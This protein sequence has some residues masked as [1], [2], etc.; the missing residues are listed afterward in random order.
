MRLDYLQPYLLDKWS[1]HASLAQTSKLVPRPK[2]LAQVLQSASVTVEQRDGPH[3]F[4]YQLC[5]RRLEMYREGAPED[6]TPRVTDSD[7]GGLSAHDVCSLKSAVGHTYMRD[8]RDSKQMPSTGFF[9]KTVTECGGFLGRG[10]DFCRNL[11]HAS[12]YTPAGGGCTLG[13]WG[14]L[15]LL[16]ALAGDKSCYFDRFFLGG[17]LSLRGFRSR[18]VGPVVATRD[19]VRWAKG[20]EA[21]VLAGASLSHPLPLP[22]NLKRL[23]DARF[24]VCIRVRAPVLACV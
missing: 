9:F 13:L 22:P 7:T 10:A 16:Q 11:T 14:S 23:V 2:K 8:T 12:W 21:M 3:A 5:S 24:Q 19:Q 4:T 20:G 15:G 17:P 18:G 1:L 6:D